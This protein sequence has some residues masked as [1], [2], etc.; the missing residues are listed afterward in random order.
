VKFY[1]LQSQTKRYPRYTC[2]ILLLI[3]PMIIL[4][5]ILAFT[6]CS[7]EK[8]TEATSTKKP[9]VI[10]SSHTPPSPESTADP[11][12]SPTRKKLRKLMPRKL[13][14]ENYEKLAKLNKAVFS[15]PQSPDPFI[16]RAEF[17]LENL[18]LEKA[19]RD[20][21]RGEK[22]D[23]T[24]DG[25]ILAKVK[26][27]TLQKDFDKALKECNRLLSIK[28][29][30]VEGYR[31][32]GLLVIQKDRDLKGSLKHIRK[33]IELDPE[34]YKNYLALKMTYQLMGRYQDA[35]E[36]MNKA[37]TLAPDNPQVYFIRG[38][39]KKDM[40]DLQGA[41]K[42]M[43]KSIKLNPDH[44]A[45]YMQKASIYEKLSKEKQALKTYELIVKKFSKKNPSEVRYVQ[46]QIKKLKQK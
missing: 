17:Y 8:K 26:L 5:F 4:F 27:Y 20:I 28:H 9:I 31:L 33:A 21:E 2:K 43:D 1:N 45:P 10:I 14:K 19:E 38:K 3:L 13:S 34:D 16:K 32:K 22:L 24:N 6:G 30:H 18:D 46:F 35:M 42:D 36:C 40:G 15:N 25:V 23:R 41:I 39:L 29:D 12:T 44:I 11:T 37:V 7:Q